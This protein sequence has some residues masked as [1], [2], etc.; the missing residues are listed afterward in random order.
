VQT[1]AVG[2]TTLGADRAGP[3]LHRPVGRAWRARPLV[4]K[5]KAVYIL[6]N[7]LTVGPGYLL[8]GDVFDVGCHC[9]HANF[10]FE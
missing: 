3:I 8:V 1:L 6:M 7:S 5:T 4:L 9:F 2:I 10:P